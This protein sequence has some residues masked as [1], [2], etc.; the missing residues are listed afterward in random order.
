M[1]VPVKKTP[2]RR[3]TKKVPCRQHPFDPPA[4]TL[5]PVD[6]PIE[7]AAPSSRLL[8]KECCGNLLFQE[9]QYVPQQIWKSAPLVQAALTQVSV[10]NERSS[11]GYM[12]VV[13]TGQN[14]SSMQVHPG[15]TGTL[16]ARNVSSIQVSAPNNPSDQIEGK[17]LITS[18]FKLRAHKRGRS[19]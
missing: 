1:F 7:Q 16:T 17:Y 10:Y 12:E 8:E 18:F 11:S 13:V 14:K 19:C 5:P 4:W 6:P 9:N 2:R 15:N 3:C